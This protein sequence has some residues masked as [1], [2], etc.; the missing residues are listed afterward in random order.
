MQDTESLTT[1]IRLALA[2]VFAVAAFRKWRN[3]QALERTVRRIGVSPHLAGAVVTVLPW[4][5]LCTA[6][7]LLWRA[8]AWFAALAAAVQLIVFTAVVV[9]PVVVHG[10]GPVPD[11]GC[12]GNER[13]T[14]EATTDSAVG[15]L[16]QN[17]LLMT[18]TVLV[19]TR[20]PRGTGPDAGTWLSAV[21]PVRTGAA[22][23]ACL[24]AAVLRHRLRTRRR[25]SADPPGLYGP[26]DRAPRLR[27]TQR[28]PALTVGMATYREFDSL[29][30]TLQSLRMYQDMTDIEVLVVDNY[31]CP[32]TR[33]LVHDSGWG[34]YIR[35][36]STVGTAAPRDLIFHE[37]AGAAVLCCDSHVLFEPGVLARLKD[38]YAQHQSC[39]DLLQG[40]M[41]DADGAV[42]A[43]HQENHWRGTYLGSWARD[44]RGVDPG[45]AP[46]DI[47][48]GGLGAF[49][50]RRAAWPGFNPRFRG[51]GGEEGYIHEKFRRAGG[52]TL[53]VPWLRWHHRFARPSGVPY[54]LRTEDI[55]RNYLIGHTELGWPDGELRERFRAWLAPETMTAISNEVLAPAVPAKEVMD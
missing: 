18:L 7:L 46:F 3:P 31:G 16:F 23:A 44:P 32:D 20:G 35:L 10:D 1:L 27:T 48:S 14:G 24:A 25:N 26:P 17:L 9:C 12:F 5:E 55:F 45:H 33:S 29:Y 50:C 4:V 42:L 19:L 38:H 28:A 37:A 11:C 41:I 34:R 39:Q 54:P 13:R 53:C 6:F 47:S 2:C 51:Y 52:R 40:P 36:D 8:T 30:F 22:A 15:H 49:S 43:T 21:G